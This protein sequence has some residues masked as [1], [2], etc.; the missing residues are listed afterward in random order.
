MAFMHRLL[1]L[2]IVLVCETPSKGDKEKPEDLRAKI[3]AEQLDSLPC[4]H[5]LWEQ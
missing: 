3:W 4:S 1:G 2:D 5:C